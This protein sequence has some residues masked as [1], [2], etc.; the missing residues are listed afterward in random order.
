VHD[1]TG[2]LKLWFR[3]LPTPLLPFHHYSSYVGTPRECHL[4]S[5]D[6]C[7]CCLRRAHN[8]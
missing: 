8:R 3:S 7:F 6:S 5:L 1:V 2:L 4:R